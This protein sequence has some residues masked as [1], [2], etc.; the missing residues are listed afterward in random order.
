VLR[1]LVLRGDAALRCAAYANRSE[2]AKRKFD[3]RRAWVLAD[4][5]AGMREPACS[6]F[7]KVPCVLEN[8][9]CVDEE[10]A[11]TEEKK[12]R[13]ANHLPCQVG[14]TLDVGKLGGGYCAL[15]VYFHYC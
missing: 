7:A 11:G 14:R 2:T 1:S 5:G 12:R 10:R 13:F 4:I 6:G 9:I 3:K 15:S 8:S